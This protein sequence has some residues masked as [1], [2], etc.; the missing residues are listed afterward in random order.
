MYVRFLAILSDQLPFTNKINTLIM[1]KSAFFCFSKSIMVRAPHMANW[2]GNCGFLPFCAHFRRRLTNRRWAAF[3]Q[4]ILKSKHHFFTEALFYVLNHIF[5]LVVKLVMF[6]R[7][8]IPAWNF[9]TL[10][11]RVR[12]TWRRHQLHFESITEMT[13]LRFFA[14]ELRGLE[15]F[16]RFSLNI[17]Q[18]LPLEFSSVGLFAV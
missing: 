9:F 1:S 3:E 2:L 13:L 4:S 17:L 12:V 11:L 15:C 18:Y 10:P 14:V 8:E 16:G 6:P 5:F 7:A